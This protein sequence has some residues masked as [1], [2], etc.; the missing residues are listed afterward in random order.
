MRGDRAEMSDFPLYLTTAAGG[1]DRT[2][3]S[4]G[5]F[6]IALNMHAPALIVVVRRFLS[7]LRRVV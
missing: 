1:I 4:L 6:S 2:I 7:L 3:H 5:G